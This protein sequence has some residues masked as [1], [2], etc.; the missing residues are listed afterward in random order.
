MATMQPRTTSG[1]RTCSRARTG[2]PCSVAAPIA[3]VRPLVD[4]TA[5]GFALGPATRARKACDLRSVRVHSSQPESEPS[6]GGNDAL[7]TLKET[8]ALD[9]L[10]DRMLSARSQQ[11]VGKRVSCMPA[12]GYHTASKKDVAQT[13]QKGDNHVRCAH[14]A[15]G[16]H[17]C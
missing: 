8:A 4:R 6:A 12:A 17:C 1:A 3:A 16:H 9:E 11:Q 14:C 13:A 10:I 5:S 7:K 2:Q 15:A